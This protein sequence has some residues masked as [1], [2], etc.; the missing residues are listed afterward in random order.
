MII[1]PPFYESTNESNNIQN[2]DK[3]WTRCIYV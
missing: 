1:S 2:I 3:I